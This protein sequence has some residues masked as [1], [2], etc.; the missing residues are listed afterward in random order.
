MRTRLRRVGDD[1]RSPVGSLAVRRA[2]LRPR[3][4]ASVILLCLRVLFVAGTC[5]VPGLVGGGERASL[6]SSRVIRRA[7]TVLDCLVKFDDDDDEDKDELCI[8]FFIYSLGVY[9][10]W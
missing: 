10:Q 6:H 8:S 2:E 5:G 4:K 1:K 7:L 9:S 3:E